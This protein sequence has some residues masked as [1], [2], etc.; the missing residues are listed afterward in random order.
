MK[1][2]LKQFWLASK[3]SQQNIIFDLV[4]VPNCFVMEMQ[5]FSSVHKRFN[6]MGLTQHLY[7]Y[8]LLQTF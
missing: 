5:I 8:A 3:L 2:S 6:Y 1:P 7:N 4:I